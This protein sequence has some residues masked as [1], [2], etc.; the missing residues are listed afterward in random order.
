MNDKEII[1][2]FNS[3][4]QRAVAELQGKYGDYI[5]TVSYRILGDVQDADECVNDAYL[6]VWNSIPPDSPDD[7]GAYVFRICRN[8]SVDRLRRNTAKKRSADIISID[9]ELNE[10]V[11]DSAEDAYIK[12][13]LKT[14][15]NAFLKS[16]KKRERDIFLLRYY[17]SYS[18]KE[19]AE[20]FG[21]D[22]DYVRV[23]LSRTRKKL[24]EFLQ[25]EGHI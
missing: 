23:L 12:G 3:R 5:K 24:K 25:K 7:L 16:L 4:D 15:I 9:G 17:F 8:L 6:A 19:I 11:G 10:C 21:T 2:L 13:E 1:D 22:D 20:R 18:A 14:V